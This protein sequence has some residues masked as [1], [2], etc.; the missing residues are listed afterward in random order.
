[1]MLVLLFSLLAI[2]LRLNIGN[3]K[4]PLKERL[5]VHVPM[6]VY[7]GWI[8]VATIANVTAFLVSVNWDGLGIS[9][10]TWTALVISVG[11]LITIL[12]LLRRKDIAYSLVV[13][14][15]LLGIYIK[16]TTPPFTNSDVATIALIAMVLIA[17]GILAVLVYHLMKRNKEE[18]V[19]KP[20]S[21][22]K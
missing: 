1:M 10:L 4:A 9:Q 6:S 15:A 21:K 5:F 16:R 8:T 17:V 12:M 18:P 20:T 22:K 14:W 2:Y 7:L 13:L 19:K 11:V 3:A